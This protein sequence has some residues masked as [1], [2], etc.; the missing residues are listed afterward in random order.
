MTKGIIYILTNEAMEGYVKIGKTS[1]NVEERMRQLDTT[2]VPLPFECYH[3]SEVDDMDK[4]EKLLHDAFD[5]IRTRPRREF[6]EIAPE[7]VRS[8]LRLAEVADVTPRG[9]VV[10]DAADSIALEKAHKQRSRFNFSLISIEAGT[11]LYHRKDET[12]T[13]EVLNDR[14]V[15]YNG[16]RTSLSR[17]ALDAYHSLGYDWKSVSGPETWMFEGKSLDLLRKEIEYGEE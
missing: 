14:E 16:E 1:N 13:C 2:S 12:I 5:D 8:A 3:A 7:R 11:I 9:E 17:A 6:F 4:A 15:N 10:E